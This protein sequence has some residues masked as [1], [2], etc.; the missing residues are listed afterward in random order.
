[1]VR[2]PG[3]TITV[4][5]T[6]ALGMGANTAMFSAIDAVVLQPLPF[7]D[8]DRLVRLTQVTDT[9][10]RNTAAVRLDEWGARTT[11][12]VAI[13]HHVG[14]D[15]SDTTGVDPERV[16]RVT[17][18]PR[19]LDVVGIR[20]ALG[21]GFTD[22]EHRLG[23]P[24]VALISD[25]YWRYRFNSDPH[26][27]EQSVRMGDRSYAIVG[28]LPP[29]FGFPEEDIDWWVPQWSDAPWAQAREFGYEGVGRLKPGVSLEQATADLER[30][31]R[32]LAVEYPKTDAQ[33][34]P[35]V[36]PL[37]E[38]VVGG[39]SRSLWLLLA[40]VSMLLLIA[41]TN[42]AALLLARG[43]QRR[44]EVAIR[45]AIGG[46]RWSVASQLLTESVVLAIAGA[47][48]GVVVAIGVAAGLRALAPTLPRLDQMALNGR[49]LMY[50]AAATAVVAL[51]CGVM[52]AFRGTRVAL[53]ADG[54]RTQGSPRQRLQWLLVGVQVALSV[55]LL[56]GA[57]LLARSLDALSRVDTG[58]DPVPVLTFRVSGSFGE[59]RR[60]QPHGAAHQS[61]AGRTGEVAANRDGRDDNHT[62]R[63]DNE[64]CLRIPAGGA[65]RPGRYARGSPNFASSRRA[66]SV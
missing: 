6:L 33:I 46:S 5:G 29:S 56:A 11:T 14:E 41:C 44:N 59:D 2:T 9:G 26:V 4:I 17:V 58:F 30:V 60:L 53:R 52:P 43:A 57:G 34:Q 16:R 1:M 47:A 54:G 19:F 55:T 12:F 63:C 40:A 21:R 49:V 37:K 50:T 64:L 27:L 18:G 32:Q 7:P 23:G 65:R 45:Y 24:N 10:E 48:A 38:A 35:R 25:R 61:L 28:V 42:I 36:V 20:P 62:A 3:F 22:A 51:L 13:T 31:Q 66:T 15:V 8:A 39:V